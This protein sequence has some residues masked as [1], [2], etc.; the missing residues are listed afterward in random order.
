MFVL[1]VLVVLGGVLLWFEMLVR[2][3][4]LTLLLVLVPVV[5][6]LAVFPSLRRAGWRLAETF[7]ALAAAKFVIVV[8]LSLGLA[9]LAGGSAVAVMTGIV[10]LL[11]GCL[12]PFVLLKMVPVMESAAL[13][14][15]EGLRQ[16][17][18]RTVV[19]APQHPLAGA[20]AGML[21]ATELPGPAPRPDDLGLP[22]FDGAGTISFPDDAEEKIVP[23]VGEP[24]LRGGH[25]A[26]YSDGQGPVV[27]WHF[28]E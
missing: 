6:P 5:A 1:A 23:P 4:L 3:A 19:G 18:W 9:E 27:G 21:P 8:A 25:V 7:V 24:R 26:Y 22:L 10:T 17:G 11:L 12:A 2:S 14:S 28:D 13:H 16:R 15:L 20:I